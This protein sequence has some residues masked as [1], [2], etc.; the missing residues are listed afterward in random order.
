VLS[1][2][3]AKGLGL[4]ESQKGEEGELWMGYI[5]ITPGLK[6]GLALFV[7]DIVSMRDYVC[8]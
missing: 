5:L 1:K 6:S 4:A 3:T 7:V 2:K 8:P